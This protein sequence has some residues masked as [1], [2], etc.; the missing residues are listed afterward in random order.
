MPTEGPGLSA[1]IRL[2]LEPPDIGIMAIR[3]T[4]TPMPP[5]QWVK[6][7]HIREHLERA[8]ISLRIDAPVVVKP[9][10]VSNNA[11]V[12]DGISPVSTN[13]TAPAIPI[14][15]QLKAVDIQPSLRYIT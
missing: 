10:I 11:S 7:L 5:I 15:I 6:L 8:S 3:K 9:E 2:M 12:Y 1:L 14:T 13:G 4:K